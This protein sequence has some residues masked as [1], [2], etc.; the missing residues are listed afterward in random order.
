[1]YNGVWK[2]QT[3]WSL[4]CIFF[5]TFLWNILLKHDLIS[6]YKF[7]ENRI[8]V[9]VILCFLNLALNLALR[10]TWWILTKKQIN[11]KVNFQPHFNEIIFSNVSFLWNT[12]D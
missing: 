1:M 7:P 2:W 9:L 11:R 5:K 12:P 3:G 4:E 10:G 8:H 6:V